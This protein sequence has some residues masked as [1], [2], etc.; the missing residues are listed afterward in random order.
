[1]F[2]FSQDNLSHGQKEREDSL[3]LSSESA[4]F[5]EDEEYKAGQI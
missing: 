3:Q 2:P 1:M 5:C 4:V